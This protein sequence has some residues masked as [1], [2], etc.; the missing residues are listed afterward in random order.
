MRQ[1]IEEGFIL[2]VLEN[3]TTYATYYKRLK[4]CEDDPNVERKQAA[5]ALAR[6]LR[7][8]APPETEPAVGVI[9]FKNAQTAR[10]T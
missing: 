2:D 6:S 7:L 4:T 1:T 8:H 5:R 3:Y 9:C 10:S